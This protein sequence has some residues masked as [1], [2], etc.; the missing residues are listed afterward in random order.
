M[1]GATQMPVQP[2]GIKCGSTSDICPLCLLRHVM[3][4]TVCR[5]GRKEGRKEWRMERR[6]AITEQIMQMLERRGSQ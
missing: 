5:E 4:T 1:V 6:N 3:G 2:S